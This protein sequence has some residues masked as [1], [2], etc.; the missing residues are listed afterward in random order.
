MEHGQMLVVLVSCVKRRAT[1]LALILKTVREMDVLH[2]VLHVRLLAELF[3]TNVTPILGLAVTVHPFNVGLQ[4]SLLIFDS[5]SC[6][7]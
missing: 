3:A 2:V 5:Q 1:I 7:K 4:H 6:K